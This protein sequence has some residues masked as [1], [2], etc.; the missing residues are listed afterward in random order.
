VEQK[1]NQSGAPLSP[2]PTSNAMFVDVDSADDGPSNSH[3]FRRRSRTGEIAGTDI[4]MSL[5]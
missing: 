3:R 4:G 5:G 2:Y 1:T